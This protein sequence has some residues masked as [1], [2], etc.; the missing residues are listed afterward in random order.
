[1]VTAWARPTNVQFF[2]PDS[3]LNKVSHGERHRLGIDTF[4]NEMTDRILKKLEGIN[5]TLGE[6]VVHAHGFAQKLIR[7]RLIVNLRYVDIPEGEHDEKTL[8]SGGQPVPA[9][10]TST[11]N[12]NKTKTSKPMSTGETKHKGKAPKHEVSKIIV[13][14]FVEGKEFSYQNDMAKGRVYFQIKAEDKRKQSEISDDLNAA[15]TK[16]ITEIKAIGYDSSWNGT[17]LK[18]WKAD[19]DNSRTSTPAPAPKTDST[20]Q[21]TTDPTPSPFE[22]FLKSLNDDQRDLLLASLGNLLLPRTISEEDKNEIKKGLIDE[23][24]VE[25][26]IV[27]KDAARILS[28][29]FLVSP[30]ELQE[31]FCS[32]KQN[33]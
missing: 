12:N 2:Q 9:T 24:M 23:V 19:K 33:S 21:T 20:T 3:T 13:Q 1:L 8:H 17:C 28:D 27:T 30:K 32:V 31:K 5:I 11:E 22:L 10:N 26:G 18:Y 29:D 7:N 25:Y 14:S 6:G 16:I 4:T 15:V